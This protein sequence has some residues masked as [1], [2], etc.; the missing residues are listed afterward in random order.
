MQKIQSHL[1]FSCILT[2]PLMVSI[3]E[4]GSCYK[5]TCFPPSFLALLRKPLWK[6]L[7]ALWDKPSSANNHRS[8][9]KLNSGEWKLDKIHYKSWHSN[10]ELSNANCSSVSGLPQCSTRGQILLSLMAWC[11]LLIFTGTSLLIKISKIWSLKRLSLIVD[12]ISAATGVEWWFWF[13]SKGMI[14]SFFRRQWFNCIC[15]CLGAEI[16][17]TKRSVDK[18]SS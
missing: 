14:F 8:E 3:S 17:R 10:W 6:G 18:Y 7:M 2:V 12:A 13:H 15:V 11:I 1:L 9:V 5:E 16:C 4:E